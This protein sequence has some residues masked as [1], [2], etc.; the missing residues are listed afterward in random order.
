MSKP[1]IAITIDLDPI[2]H[3]LHVRGYEPC[4]WTNLNSVF[5]DAVPRFLEILDR[6][7]ARATFFVVGKDL[8]RSGNRDILAEVVQW[9]HEVANHTMN[10]HQ[11]FADLPKERKRREIMEA[12]ELISRAIAREIQG[13]RAPGWNIDNETISILEEINYLYDSSVFPS[14]MRI[15][16]QMLTFLK[17]RGRLGTC[18]GKPMGLMFAPLR[19]YHPSVNALWRRG[20]RR[21]IESPVAVV[22]KVRFPFFGTMAFAYGLSLFRLCFGALA[23]NRTPFVY[24]MHGLDLVDYRHVQDERLGTKPGLTWPLDRKLEL[25]HQIFETF[26]SQYQLVTLADYVQEVS[27]ANIPIGGE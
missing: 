5:E 15:P 3:Y 9:G 13:F 6:Y 22:P 14:Y 7:Q 8:E 12:H 23:C 10:H 19:P 16:M 24:E 17:E 26:A 20:G 25:C 1:M 4:S 21:I 11:I 27:D 18:F 2:W